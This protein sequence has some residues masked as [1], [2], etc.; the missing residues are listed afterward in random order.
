MLMLIVGI[1]LIDLQSLQLMVKYCS[2]INIVAGKRL[3]TTIKMR[4]H[5]YLLL[6]TTTLLSF[7]V[8]EKKNTINA[9]IHFC[10]S[11]CKKRRPMK[12]Q[13]L[14]NTNAWVSQK[15]R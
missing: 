7:I 5:Y 1:C 12:M 10:L 4:F 3:I 11:I 2:V 9:K 13:M 8:R 14:K 15:C 6:S